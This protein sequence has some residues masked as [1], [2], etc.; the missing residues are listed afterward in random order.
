MEDWGGNY[1]LSQYGGGTIVDKVQGE[2][3]ETNGNTNRPNI[4]LYIDRQRFKTDCLPR[5]LALTLSKF[6]EFNVAVATRP[7]LVHAER[8]QLVIPMLGE[9]LEA[10][11]RDSYDQKLILGSADIAQIDSY[12]AFLNAVPKWRQRYLDISAGDVA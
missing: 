1:T 3:F 12:E 4:L 10:G 6:R 2:P 7:E 9:G 11:L 8:A 5:T